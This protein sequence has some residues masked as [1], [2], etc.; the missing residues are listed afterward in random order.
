MK[1]AI[2]HLLIFQ[3]VH[4]ALCLGLPGSETGVQ[5]RLYEGLRKNDPTTSKVISAYHLNIIPGNLDFANIPILK[6]RDS[7]KRVFNVK[8]VKLIT[9]RNLL[10]GE[11]N[12]QK[13][14]RLFILNK[15]N[16][17][18]Q[19]TMISRQKNQFQ[20]NVIENKK[21]SPPLL[22]TKIIIPLNKTAVIGFEGSDNK[23]YFISFFR[24]PLSE[25]NKMKETSGKTYKKPALIKK[26]NPDYPEKAKKLGVQGLEILQAQI[27]D[28]G[29]IFKLES[30]KTT[31][32]LLSQSAM[33]AI[34]Q[35]KYTPGMVSGKPIKVPL[36]VMVNYI[37]EKRSQQPVLGTVHFSIDS[38]RL[39]LLKKVA[40]VYPAEALKKNIQ[41]MVIM[42]AFIDKNGYI[43]HTKIFKGNPILAE[44]AETAMKKWRF[45]P[46]MIGGKRQSIL[47][48]VT[49]SF[50]IDEKNTGR[51]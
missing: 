22:E 43:S 1:K 30:I 32:P 40:P 27:D 12:Q 42:M 45:E 25:T 18:I 14:S 48:T 15:K 33:F 9:F 24:T 36:T 16:V 51:Q 21:K 7:L 17:T 44:A 5:L 28:S 11:K 47:F 46:Y 4:L 35:W 38:P 23:I 13:S 49:L 2:H 8:D 39:R 10:I 6:E 31:H 29:N 37:L 3:M 50:T 20:V 41:G 34:K 26:V 19:L